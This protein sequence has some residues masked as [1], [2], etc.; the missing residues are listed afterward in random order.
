MPLV[1]DRNSEI[2]KLS[3]R[4]LDGNPSQK[5]EPL[6]TP[7]ERAARA[8]DKERRAPPNTINHHLLLLV[9]ELD[10]FQN[11]EVCV[12]ERGSLEIVTGEGSKLDK[13]EIVV[14]SFLNPKLI[15][16]KYNAVTCY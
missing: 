9:G 13:L 3:P 15:C 6:L 2:P 16:R 1:Q 14:F 7:P 8:Q 12:L 4:L 10:I 11:D 5:T